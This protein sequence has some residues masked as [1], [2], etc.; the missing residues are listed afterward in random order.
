MLEEPRPEDIGGHFWEN[1][2]FLLVLLTVGIVVIFARAVTA[3][4]TGVAGVTWREKERESIP[5]MR[6]R[7]WKWLIEQHNRLAA[8]ARPI[9][10]TTQLLR[11][12]MRNEIRLNGARCSAWNITSCIRWGK[13]VGAKKRRK[14]QSFQ[15]VERVMKNGGVGFDIGYHLST[16]ALWNPPLVPTPK[17]KGKRED[18]TRESV[19]D[20]KALSEVA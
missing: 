8:S 17:K 11:V 12:R 18:S 4:D 3:A 9:A 6:C 19:W 15:R 13:P 14:I 1:A 5:L 16:G 2:S 20:E 10:F 7:P